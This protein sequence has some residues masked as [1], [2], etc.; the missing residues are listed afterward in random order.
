MKGIL[1]GLA[2][3]C[4]NNIIHRDIKPENIMLGESG[5]IKIVDFGFAYELNSELIFKM[6]G[7]HGYFAPELLDKDVN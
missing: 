1:S 7:T 5:K 6:C 3:L 2:T 4:K